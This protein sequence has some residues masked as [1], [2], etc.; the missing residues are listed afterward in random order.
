VI[1]LPETAL[2]RR[3]D[4]ILTWIGQSISWIW[5]ILLATIVFNVVLRYAFGE[6]RI[7]L[8][9]IQWHLYSTGFLLGIAYTFQVDGHVRVDVLHER[10]SPRIQAWLELYGIILCVLPFTALILVF[11]TPFVITSFEL[12]EVSVSPG[13]LPYRW[14]I[15][16]MLFTGFFLL[17]LAS[18]SR[19]SR[20]WVYL[21]SQSQQS[22][23]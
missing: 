14:L 7:E 21:F 16:S 8:E 5:L 2:S 10:L 4:P 18:L 15:K 20:V 22:S 12:G 11:V 17:L 13:G 19:L 23:Q 1:S 3:V 6:G 9:E